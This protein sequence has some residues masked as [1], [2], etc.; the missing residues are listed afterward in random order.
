M[1]P[2]DMESGVAFQPAARAALQDVA[3]E[4]VPTADEHTQTMAT[5]YRGAMP[6]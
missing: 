1:P 5:K 2:H 3:G 6:A 4:R